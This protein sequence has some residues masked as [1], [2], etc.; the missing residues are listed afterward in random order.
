MNTPSVKPH[1][2]GDS[3]K[4]SY[5]R[6]LVIEDNQDMAESLRLLLELF[7][8][9]ATVAY[10][11]QAGVEAAEQYIPDVVICDIGLPGLDGYE[12]ARRLRG[13]AV[14]A[15]ACLIALTAYGGEEDRRRSREAGFEHHLVKPI[16]FDKLQEILHLPASPESIEWPGLNSTE[17]PSQIPR[18]V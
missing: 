6:I 9:E 17:E 12:V 1:I 15:K 13:N 18:G 11:G 4:R 7:G 14:T 5:K 3:D 8:Y 2:I 16:F 10:S